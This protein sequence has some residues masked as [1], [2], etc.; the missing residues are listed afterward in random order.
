M[1]KCLNKLQKYLSIRDH[2]VYELK[3]KLKKH[4]SEQDIKSALDFA[5]SKKWLKPEGELA[6][7]LVGELNR[8][9]KGWLYIVQALKKKNLPVPKKD[10][11]QEG[12]KAKYWIKKHLSSHPQKLARILTNKGFESSVIAEELSTAGF[13]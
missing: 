8:K 10:L 5:L 7:Q 13:F 9:N 3:N 6:V 12:K 1:Q 4:F 2:S 11:H